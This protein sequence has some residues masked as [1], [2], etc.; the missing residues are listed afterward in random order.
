M[1]EDLIKGLIKLKLD[2]VYA[3]VERLPEKE[4][5]QVRTLG[6]VVLE[7]LF[8]YFGETPRPQGDQS[9]DQLKTIVID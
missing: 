6:N 4:A 3:M 7:A 9:S 1:N 8:E 2:T 5:Q